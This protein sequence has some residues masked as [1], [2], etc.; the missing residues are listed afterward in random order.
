MT[1]TA[2]HSSTLRMNGSTSVCLDP[3]WTEADKLLG[4][5]AIT[6]LNMAGLFTLAILIYC[7]SLKAYP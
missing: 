4:V 3:Y 5:V 7:G 6:V 2:Y 1:M